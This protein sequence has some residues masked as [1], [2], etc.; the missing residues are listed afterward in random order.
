MSIFLIQFIQGGFQ[1]EQIYLYTKQF[2]EILNQPQQAIE[3]L[4]VLVE[5]INDTISNQLWYVVVLDIAYNYI[6]NLSYKVNNEY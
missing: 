1:T 5:Q 2:T 4:E 3:L 6:C